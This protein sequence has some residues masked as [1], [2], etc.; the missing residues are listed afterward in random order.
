LEID[1][2]LNDQAERRGRGRPQLRSDEETL[3][4][5]LQAAGERFRADG[6]AGTSMCAVAL[7]A[8][9]STKTLYRLVPNKE[10][11]FKQVI[12]SRIGRFILEV[13]DTDGGQGDLPDDLER[14]LTVYGHLILD[15]ET[16]AI[17]RLVVS[18]CGR[19]PEIGR[20]FYEN[21]VN[22]TEIY[23]AEWL[24]RRC[25][26]GQIKLN[27]PRMAAGILRGMMVTERERSLL[28]CQ[29]GPP[30]VGH[31]AQ[32]AKECARLFLKGCIT[33]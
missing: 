23:M 24:E 14:L 28:L 29:A 31:I 30:D 8:G 21:A 11:L 26:A 15:P 19:F 27:D 2:F 20:A 10:E 7:G 9:V 33:R 12:A 25:R 5:I 17:Y 22:G 16:L 4:L 18:E 32:R 1:V 3:D 6:Y 13:G